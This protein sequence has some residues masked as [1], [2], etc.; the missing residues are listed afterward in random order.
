MISETDINSKVPVENLVTLS[1]SYGGEYVGARHTKVRNQE[2]VITDRQSSLGFPPRSVSK[3]EWEVQLNVY[4]I[5]S[6]RINAFITVVV[7]GEA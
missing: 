5:A 3:G 1:L 2:V 7:E 6:E 4:C